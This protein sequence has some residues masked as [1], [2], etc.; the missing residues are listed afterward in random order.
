MPKSPDPTSAFVT[1]AVHRARS[2]GVWRRADLVNEVGD[3]RVRAQ[4][5]AGRWQSPFAQTVVLHNGPLTEQQRMWSALTAA[6]PGAVLHGLSALE[7][8]GFRG[9]PPE[10]LTIVIPRGSANPQHHQLTVPESWPLCIRWSRR[11]GAEDVNAGAVPPRTRVSRSVVD[12]ASERVPANRARVIVLAAVQQRLVAPPALWDALSRRG[13]CRNRAIIAEAIVDATGGIDSLPERE[14]ELL[15]R[16]LALPEPT[17]Q[18]MLRRADRRLY[19]DATWEDLGI[20]VEIHGIP[21]MR[22]RNWDDDLLRLNDINIVGGLL[23]FSSYAIRHRSDRVAEQLLRM[24]H[25]RGWVG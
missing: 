20:R 3:S 12:A 8:D 15:R 16:L 7:L 17:R 24:F 11:L 2:V 22:A 5:R 1:G 10:S 4:V 9:F 14:F 13:R 21:H 25:A 6:P 19:L 23:V 18:Q